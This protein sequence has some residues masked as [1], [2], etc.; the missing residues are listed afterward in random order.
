MIILPLAIV[1]FLQF[2]VLK[3]FLLVF[4]FQK[5]RGYSLISAV[6]YNF[7]AGKE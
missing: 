4:P 7:R 6:G 5:T 2:R 3:L 1:M